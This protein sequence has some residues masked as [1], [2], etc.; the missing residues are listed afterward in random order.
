MFS[1]EVYSQPDAPDPVLD[2][3]TVL[4]LVRHHY[5]S[6]QAVTSVDESGGEARTY[7]IDNKYIFKTQ[8]PHRLRL[9]TSQK[10]VSFFLTK[11]AAPSPDALD[12]R[13]S[14]G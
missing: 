9:R 11:L 5:A 12:M 1:R 4:R 13:Q 10:K 2:S 14:R 8:R 7:L 3:K 6:A